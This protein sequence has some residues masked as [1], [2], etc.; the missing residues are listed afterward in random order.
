MADTPHLPIPGAAGPLSAVQRQWHD[1]LRLLEAAEP[2]A[3]GR[4]V[5]WTVSILVAL[6]IGWSAIGQLDIIASAEGRL[7]PQTLVKI[8]QPSEAGVVKALLV[9]EGQSVK[10]GQP[11]AHL[12]STLA[13]A[14]RSSARADLA[15]QQMQARRIEAELSG[16]PLSARADDDPQLYT[17]VLGQWQANRKAYMDSLEQEQALLVK[18]EHEQRS[19]RETLAKLEQTF[20]IYRGV[21]DNM[22]SLAS[23][24]YVPAARSDEK[25]R[26]AIE[27]T[28]DVDAQKSVLAALGSGVAAQ[29]LKVEQIR[30]RYRS[31]LERELTEAHGRM[32]SC[33]RT[34]KKVST[35]KGRWYCGPRRTA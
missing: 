11:L 33:G 6:L 24:G 9:K 17:Q 2:D 8:V 26:E 27:R 3:S 20:P 14:D 12:D 30:S 16:R 4:I 13:S 19:A 32:G 23:E 5:L 1:P 35:R 21:A 10:A 25:R 7:V 15:L 28:K 29:R 34:S 22:A 18:T 31:D